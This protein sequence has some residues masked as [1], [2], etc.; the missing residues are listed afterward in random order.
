MSNNAY[1]IDRNG[2]LLGTYRKKNLWHPE[3]EFFVKGEDDHAIIETQEFGKVGLLI[4]WDLCF[5]EA[6][7][8]LLRLGVETIIAPTCWT[9]ADAGRGMKYNPTSEKLFLESLLVLRAFENEIILVFCNIGAEKGD[10][11]LG[12]VGVSQITAPFVGKIAGFEHADRGVVTTKV[13][14]S[15]L[16]VAEQ[17]YKVRKDVMNEDWHYGDGSRSRGGS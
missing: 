9:Y 10:E 3:R 12:G 13:D 17:V 5:P 4:C 7:R 2:S 8:C 1:F 16:E 11:A 6:F 15:C 14:Y